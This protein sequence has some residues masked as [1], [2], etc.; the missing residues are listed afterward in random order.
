[1]KYHVEAETS[2]RIRIRLS[3]RKLTKEQ[4][5]IL[6]YAFTG[7]KGVR[8]VTV[9]RATGGAALTFDCDREEI[10][11]RL[12]LFRFENVEMMATEEAERI[13]REELRERKLH[14]DLKRKLRL[15]ILAETAA[16]IVMPMP[17]Q[18]G[19]HVWQ[20]ITLKDL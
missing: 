13:S 4:A 10:I 9:Y 18:V 15:R 5:Q 20:M 16:D 6:E 1:M 11:K 8:K 14:P 12:D 2:H 19:Y 3:T 7:M 17:V